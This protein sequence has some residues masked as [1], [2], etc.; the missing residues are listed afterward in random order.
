MGDFVAA[1]ARF[2]RG[3]MAIMETVFGG[4]VSRIR[5]ISRWAGLR[6]GV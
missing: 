4:E 6:E 3:P 5:R 2:V 1:R